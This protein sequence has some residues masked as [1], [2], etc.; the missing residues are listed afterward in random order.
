MQVND[1]AEHSAIRSTFTKLPF[2]ITIFIL[3]MLSGR[4]TIH[5]KPS[6]VAICMG[7]VQ[8]FE[9]PEL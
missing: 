2:V 9:N 6:R 1:I 4:F 8:N 5:T 3:S 7:E